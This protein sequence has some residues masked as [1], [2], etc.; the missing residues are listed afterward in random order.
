MT[1]LDLLLQWTVYPTT[2]ELLVLL[3]KLRSLLP[4]VDTALSPEAR[5]TWQKAR[6]N[7]VDVLDEAMDA[8]KQAGISSQ[9]LL[10]EYARQAS[11]AEI[12]R[13]AVQQAGKLRDVSFEL[14]HDTYELGRQ[15]QKRAAEWLQSPE[16]QAKKQRVLK[17][18]CRSAHTAVRLAQ[19]AVRSAHEAARRIGRWATSPETVAARQKLVEG[20]QDVSLAGWKQAKRE[21]ERAS[22]TA[23]QRLQQALDTVQREKEHAAGR[24]AERHRIKME[25]LLSRL[26]QLQSQVEAL[27][28]A[29]R[30]SVPAA[31]EATKAPPK[32]PPPVMLPSVKSFRAQLRTVTVRRRHSLFGEK[33]G[34]K[35]RASPRKRRD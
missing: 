1:D 3:Q 26:R 17:E 11:E 24:A 5:A 7:M 22:K 19:S 34:K 2:E 18:V 31:V 12:T 32:A 10:Q 21:W 25:R 9:Y 6:Q 13:K 4:D 15:Q 27:R 29:D 8:A 14:A 28:P 16:V 30:K 33:P 20:A 35:T 23:S